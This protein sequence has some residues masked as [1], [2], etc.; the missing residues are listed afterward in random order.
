[1]IVGGGGRRSVN[2]LKS[3]GICAERRQHSNSL[4]GSSDALKH[5]DLENDLART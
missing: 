2:L 3:S 4:L 5:I 1:M